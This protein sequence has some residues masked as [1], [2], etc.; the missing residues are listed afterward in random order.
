M[1]PR[2]LSNRELLAR[3]KSLRRNERALAIEILSHLNEVSRRRLHLELGFSSLFD[4]CVNA[5][6]YSASTAGRRVQAARCIGRFAVAAEA[7]RAGRVTITTLAMAARIMNEKNATRVLEEVDGKS[8]REVEAIVAGH[9]PL[10]VLRDRVRP[11]SIRV[12]V[13]VA[14]VVTEGGTVVG[15]AANA[16]RGDS[17]R[18]AMM[19]SAAVGRTRGASQVLALE[20]AH[21]HDPSACEKSSYSHSGSDPGDRPEIQVVQKML[22][23]FA[24]SPGFMRKVEAARSLLST[25]HPE[26]VSF[27]VLFEAA[28]DLFLEKHSPNARNR[29]RR[30][31]KQNAEQAKPLTGQTAKTQTQEVGVKRAG[32]AS[33]PPAARP[34]KTGSEQRRHIPARTRDQV[35][36]RDGGKCTYMRAGG[37][38]CGSTHNLHVDHIVPFARGGP[39]ELPNLRLLCAQHNR[40]EARRW[41]GDRPEL[42]RRE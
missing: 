18:S 5:L 31:R 2:S 33:K 1:S 32:Q 42:T 41:F 27:E 19:D 4:Y 20:G 30:E 21:G 39:N 10:S 37:R 23:Q 9:R 15:E 35:F 40:M 13:P 14:A 6:G 34:T 8:Q 36:E 22:V 7:L 3:L 25:K 29:R 24:A 26:G 11:V 17:D 38:R 28:V 12:P 16:E